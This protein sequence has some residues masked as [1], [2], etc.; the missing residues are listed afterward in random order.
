M[1]GPSIVA[2]IG[3]SIV[4]VIGPS[5]VAVIGLSIVTLI[6]VCITTFEI[7]FVVS[8]QGYIYVQVIVQRIDVHVV[9][10]VL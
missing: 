3:P 9:V 6:F 5:I 7:S 1:I 4:A 8:I 2:V 10:M